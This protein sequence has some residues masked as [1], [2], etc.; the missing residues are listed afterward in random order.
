MKIECEND[1]AKALPHLKA[2]NQAL[3]TIKAQHIN[4]IKALKTP[5][6]TIK[7][8]LQAVCVLC[9]KKVEKTP[10]KDNPKKLEDN[11][12]YTG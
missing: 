5:P 3:N 2:A 6:A 9:E 11:W 4:E 12:W 7:L 10:S 1:L 8:V